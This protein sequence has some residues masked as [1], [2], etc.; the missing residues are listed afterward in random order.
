MNLRSSAGGGSIVATLAN[1]TA[2]TI[3]EQ[4][5]YDDS[6]VKV[7]V[8]STGQVGYIFKTS[9]YVR[10]LEGHSSD[11]GRIMS[12]YVLQ[13][14]YKEVLKEMADALGTHYLVLAGILQRECAGM[15]TYTD[16]WM[17]LIR[18]EGKNLLYNLGPDYWQ[19][20]RNNGYVLYANYNAGTIEMTSYAQ[21]K[22]IVES[23][24]PP[25]SWSFR[26]NGTSI[27]SPT[28]GNIGVRKYGYLYELADLAGEKREVV[29]DA[30]SY[31]CMQLMGN[32][33]SGYKLAMSGESVLDRMATGN[34]EQ[35]E[36]MFRFLDNKLN[37]SG[38]SERAKA[39]STL[40][41]D[42]FNLDALRV[43]GKA[44]NGRSGYGDDLSDTMEIIRDKNGIS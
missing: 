14:G 1:D 35:L 44:Y 5:D 43:V 23:D 9:L 22:D 24:N 18:I 41:N 8:N 28:F 17:P 12:N 16:N 34:V 30:T 39:L 42:P 3:L 13:G 7:R 21:L 19:I 10:P 2:V 33:A 20:I 6:Y 11:N 38:S 36:F 15:P 25:G 26:K 29:F 27:N 4:T 40:K 31:G 37:N 32:S